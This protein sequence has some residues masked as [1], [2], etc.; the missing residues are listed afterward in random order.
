MSVRAKFKLDNPGDMLATMTLTMTIDAWSKIRANL[1]T[2]EWL[3]CDV[4]QA[5]DDLVSQAEAKF[6]HSHEDKP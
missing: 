4:T 3:S 2:Y 1:K 6:S 5:I